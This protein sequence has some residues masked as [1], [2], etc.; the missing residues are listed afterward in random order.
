MVQVSAT[1]YCPRKITASHDAAGCHLLPPWTDTA[2]HLSSSLAGAGSLARIAP[3]ARESWRELNN[4]STS[5]NKIKFTQ[6]THHSM[7]CIL[8]MFLVVFTGD[9]RQVTRLASWSHCHVFL[10][11]AQREKF[12]YNN[13]TQ[14][15]IVYPLLLLCAFCLSHSLSCNSTWLLPGPNFIEPLSTKICLA[16]NFFHDKNKITN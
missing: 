5:L 11:L 13:K 14:L 16:W 7:S 8:K 9:K 1:E 3:V 4:V 15:L 10:N 12:T 2:Q 6:S